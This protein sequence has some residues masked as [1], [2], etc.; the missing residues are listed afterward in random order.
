MVLQAFFSCVVH[1]YF[2]FLWVSHVLF[3]QEEKPTFFS[4]FFGK[5]LSLTKSTGTPIPT[6]DEDAPEE[7]ENGSEWV[8]AE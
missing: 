2:V 4:R 5:K 8:I 6:E 7:K 3:S 1:G